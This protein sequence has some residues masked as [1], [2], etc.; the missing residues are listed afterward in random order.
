VVRSSAASDVYK[1]QPLAL[2]QVFLAILMLVTPQ[3]F[4]AIALKEALKGLAAHGSFNGF[5]AF[6]ATLSVVART[7]NGVVHDQNW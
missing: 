3:I 7:V 5:D 4:L 6:N 2:E 1:R